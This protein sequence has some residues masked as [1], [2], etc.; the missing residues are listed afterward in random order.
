MIKAKR[1]WSDVSVR[2]EDGHRVFLD[3]RE[4]QTPYK[5][6]LIFPTKKLADAVA[7]EWESVAGEINPNLMPM[8]KM[9]NSAVERIP[10]QR[11]EIENHL[12]EYLESDLLVYRAAEPAELANKQK[13][14]DAPIE[15][16]KQHRIELTPTQGIIAVDQS[17][18]NIAHARAWL[19][20]LTNYQLVS[21][22]E[23]VVITGSFVL[24][25]AVFEG[26]MSAEEAFDLSRLDDDFQAETWGMVD[27][28]KEERDAK[29]AEI[30]LAERFYHLL[31]AT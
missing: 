28:K 25:M 14:W 26:E 24:A 1:F 10:N 11:K 20:K 5:N 8:T 29:L 19:E 13:Q 4:L 15:W 18:D 2:D 3:E 31:D 22:Y 17:P 7:E 9:S 30:L 6:P 27:V 12:L 23:Y 21:F 16:A